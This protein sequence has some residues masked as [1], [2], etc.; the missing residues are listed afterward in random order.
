MTVTAGV[1]LASRTH[2]KLRSKLRTMGNS[3]GERLENLQRRLDSALASGDEDAIKEVITEIGKEELS[4]TV[5]TRVAPASSSLDG[6]T[7]PFA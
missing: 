1:N 4:T 7:P 6:D 5:R 3:H 2:C